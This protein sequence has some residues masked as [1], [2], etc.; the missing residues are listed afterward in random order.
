MKTGFRGE[1][2]EQNGFR[3]VSHKS[4]LYFPFPLQTIPRL[5][6]FSQASSFIRVYGGDDDVGV[7]LYSKFHSVRKK[8]HNNP[9]SK[10]YIYIGAREKLQAEIRTTRI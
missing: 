3:K 2:R 5:F 7:C 9:D 1:S 4:T 8:H 10:P 6:V